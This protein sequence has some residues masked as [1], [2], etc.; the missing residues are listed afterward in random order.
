MQVADALLEVFNL[1]FEGGKALLCEAV[2][3]RLCD[4]HEW[5]GACAGALLPPDY[6][7]DLA[8]NWTLVEALLSHPFIQVQWIF[9]AKPVREA[10]LAYAR[11]SGMSAALFQR[12]DQALRQPTDSLSHDDQDCQGDHAHESE[13]GKRPGR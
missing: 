1:V 11:R 4:A 12:A 10:L 3:K 6:R 2:G 8:R 7:F 13:R 9:V 5:E